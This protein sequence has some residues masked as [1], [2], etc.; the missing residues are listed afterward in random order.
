MKTF[1]KFATIA[2]FAA[3]GLGLTSSD[4]HAGATVPGNIC[5]RVSGDPVQWA[6]TGIAANGIST[7]ACAIPI[8]HQLGTTVTF[9]VGYTESS[10]VDSDV[11][12]C[13]GYVYNENGTQLGSITP[14]I[15]SSNCTGQGPG[16]KK[17]AQKSTTVNPQSATNVYTMRCS[18][19]ISGLPYTAIESVRA[20]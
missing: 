1:G 14:E 10:S 2:F 9:R 20:F 19:P 8:D 12:R 3:A 5:E 4:V 18:T 15:N 13:N 16:C 11:I 6:N 17:T 7:L